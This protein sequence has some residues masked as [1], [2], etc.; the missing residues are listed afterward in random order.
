ML[1]VYQLLQ[2]ELG[3]PEPIAA[4]FESRTIDYALDVGF[5]DTGVG[6]MVDF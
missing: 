1:A 3:K 2:D 4:R 5:S 6:Q